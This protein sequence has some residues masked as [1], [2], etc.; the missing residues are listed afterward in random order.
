MAA[1]QRIATTTYDLEDRE[2]NAAET[3][4]VYPQWTYG[5][6]NA[7]RNYKLGV[8]AVPTS[9]TSVSFTTQ[10]GSKSW[11]FLLLEHLDEFAKLA[12]YLV[13]DGKLVEETFVRM[14]A[15]LDTTAFESSSPA[16]A[17]SQAREVLIRQAI[18]V[19]SDARREADENRPLQANSTDSLPDHP[20]LAF[21][22]RLIIRSSEKEVAK[23]LGVSPSEVQGLVEHALDCLR[24]GPTI[25]AS[26]GG[27]DA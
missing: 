9:F 27:Y 13:A 8:T 21:M 19:L 6:R 23:F 14:M 10:P 25:P 26:T 18:A 15:K 11:C 12:W 4:G 17:Y 24:V 22:L 1:M 20:R 7:L 16:L 2:I 3:R 5:L